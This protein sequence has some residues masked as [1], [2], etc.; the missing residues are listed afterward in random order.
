MPSFF[1]SGVPEYPPLL[2]AMPRS[3]PS[4]RRPVR[5][6]V[7]RSTGAP[8]NR[9]VP[10]VRDPA[11][12]VNISDHFTRLLIVPVGSLATATN[13]QFQEEAPCRFDWATTPRTSPPRPPKAPSRFYDYLG[14]GWGLLFSHPKDFTPVC[15]TELGAFAKRKA[16]FDQRGVK[17]IGVSVDPLE[18]HQGWVGDIEE[19]QG[20]ALNFPLIADPEREG[21]R[22]LRHDPPERQRHAHGA[23]GVRDRPRQEG[24]ADH[25]L[26]G[27]HRAAT[28]TRS[29]GSS[30][31]CSS[32]PTTRWPRRSNWTDGDDV[33]I[34]PAVS[35]RGGQGE[36]PEGLGRARS[37]TCGS[38]P[39]PTSSPHS[40]RAPGRRRALS[41]PCHREWHSA[42]SDRSEPGW[43]QVAGVDRVAVD[44]H[45]EVQVAPGRLAG[46][47]DVADHLALRDVCPADTMIDDWWP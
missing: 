24:Q 19:T 5:P 30:T 10:G 11:T 20:T 14:D 8:V 16:E 42:A 27:E 25:H 46:R 41:A 33:I 17:I 15:T 31:R 4:R 32:P 39:S 22:P 45:L 29:C 28:S 35:R 43:L 26:P 40:R 18:S 6:Q 34:V 2:V 9:L 12:P 1:G 47:A 38:R 13:P 21:R 7:H 36:V 23:L 44:P 37:P 3:R